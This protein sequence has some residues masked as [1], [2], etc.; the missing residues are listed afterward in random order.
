MLPKTK[1]M[2]CF[3]IL[4]ESLLKLIL[5]ILYLKEFVKNAGIIGSYSLHCLRHTFATR[6]IEAGVELP[7]L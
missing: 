1:I 5:L 2:C 3:A 7:V 6:C 4:M